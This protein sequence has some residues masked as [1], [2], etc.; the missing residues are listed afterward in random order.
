M[1]ASLGDE[2]PDEAERCSLCDHPRMV[3]EEGNCYGI[4]KHEW[5]ADGGG[6]CPCNGFELRQRN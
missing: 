1:K 3:H 5:M 2:E 6:E 4:P